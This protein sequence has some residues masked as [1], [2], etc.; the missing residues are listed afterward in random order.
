MERCE[1]R[2]MERKI[3][4]KRNM[5]LDALHADAETQR[6]MDGGKYRWMIKLLF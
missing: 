5:D 6:S 4:L 2:G 3:I 1:R